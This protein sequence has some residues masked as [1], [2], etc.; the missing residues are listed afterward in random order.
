MPNYKYKNTL[1][2]LI[3]GKKMAEEKTKKE[4]T[5]SGMTILAIDMLNEYLDPKGKIYCGKCREIIP[6]IKR[7]IE[8]GR[9]KS[10]P[11][12]YVNTSHINDKDPETEKWGVHALRD[13]WGAE[14]SPE[15]KPKEKDIVVFKRTYDGFYNTELEIT[16][17]SLDTKIVVACGIHTHV[18][19][20]MTSL[21][22]FYRGFKVI[23]IEDCMTT[24]YKPNH[25]SRLRFYKTHVGELLKLNEFIERFK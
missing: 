20:L 23:A 13:T 3:G 24:G 2:H 9:G 11:I 7:L 12:V 6:N 25:D 21:G 10:F 4:N 18:C 5:N 19:V 1:K 15:L 17:R 14:V 16:L 8:F 22:A